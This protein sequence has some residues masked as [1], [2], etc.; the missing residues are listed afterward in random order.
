MQ[1]DAYINSFHPKHKE[2]VLEVEEYFQKNFSNKTDKTIF[3]W[4]TNDNKNICEICSSMD[5]IERENLE[6]FPFLPPVHPNCK[7]EIIEVSVDNEEEGKMDDLIIS[8]EGLE[9]LKEFEGNLNFQK[10]LGYYKNGK[11]Y[12]YYDIDNKK[13]LGNPT[14]GY[15]YKI[16][17]NELN[18]FKNGITE[19]EAEMLL[20]NKIRIVEQEY[21]RFI[22]RTDFN[23]NQLD[24]ILI[25]L[26]NV[27]GGKNFA[28]SELRY[29]LKNGLTGVNPRTGKTL[30]QEF[31][32][33][34]TSDGV[35][36]NGLKNRRKKEWDLF[37]KK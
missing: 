23:Q 26:Y 22:G 35:F 15:G 37:I 5:G 7:C 2:K 13:K 19:K 33:W 10:E 28:K 12:I 32:E 34:N 9:L 27:G 17:K 29:M 6:N 21:K 36:M 18:K 20:L 30:E 25:F 16:N 4:I 31:K 24:S 3:R 1:S 8:N 14:I 11:F